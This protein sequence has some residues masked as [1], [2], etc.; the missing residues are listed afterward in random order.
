MDRRKVIQTIPVH[1]PGH[2][3]K[4]LPPHYQ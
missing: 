2:S 1:S 4:P 3:G